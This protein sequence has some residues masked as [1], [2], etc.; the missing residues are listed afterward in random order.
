M[1]QVVIDDENVRTIFARPSDSFEVIDPLLPVDDL[2]YEEWS[3]TRAKGALERVDQ[4]Q[5]VLPLQDAQEVEGEQEHHPFWQSERCSRAT[6]RHGRFQYRKWN[7]ED[8]L[9]GHGRDRGTIEFRQRPH[10]V[11][12][13]EGRPELLGKLF[14]LPGPLADRVAAGEKLRSHVPHEL[15][16][17]IGVHRDDVRIEVAVGFF[18]YLERMLSATVPSRRRERREVDPCRLDD[19]SGQPTAFS[20][21]Q[22][23]VEVPRNSD[24]CL[25]G[26]RQ[27]RNTDA[28]RR[29]DFRPFARAGRH[30]DEHA[31]HPVQFGL[32]ERPCMTPD[33]PCMRVGKNS[34]ISLRKA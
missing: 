6:R 25:L 2:E 5:R 8:G 29:R 4:S 24:A 34:R 1:S 21:P 33:G 3:L 7:R 20:D 28:A 18:F 23:G 10:L 14:H 11:D 27:H 30:C 32:Y 12:E 17:L 16:E 31:G 15:G 26:F 13:F 9:V 22:L 19:P